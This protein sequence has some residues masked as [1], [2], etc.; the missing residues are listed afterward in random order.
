VLC[1]LV[2]QAVRRSHKPYIGKLALRVGLAYNSD[3]DRGMLLSQLIA[4]RDREKKIL[5]IGL[6]T[7]RH[8]V[9]RC[10]GCARVE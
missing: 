5:R 8:G 10:L 6:F 4:L 2:Y 3:L 7:K 9:M 1:H